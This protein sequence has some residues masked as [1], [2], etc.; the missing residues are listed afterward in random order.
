ML[1]STFSVFSNYP[2]P[3]L[4]CALLCFGAPALM[5]S[6]IYA[7]LNIPI[8]INRGNFFAATPGIYSLQLLVQAAVG[9]IAFLFGRG[10]I[11]WMA[12]QAH[13][14][15]GE[16]V[17]LRAALQASV[18][19][20]RALLMSTVLYGT[21]ITLALAGLA[22]LLREV[23]LEVSNFRWVRNDANSVLNVA[24]VRSLAIVPP[25]P[26]SPFAEL[27]AAT[28]YQLSRQGNVYFA[29]GNFP[30]DSR[31]TQTTSYRCGR[32]GVHWA[33]RHRNV[34]VYAQRSHHA[35]AST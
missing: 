9:A 23:R 22:V 30:F 33:I 5:G 27:H 32:I 34:I 26:G 28:R 18:G 8:H 11:V 7:A 21:L 13:T 15:T 4:V 6:A 17:S 12:Q 1:H 19:P 10:A 31:Q 3:V 16:P 20:W 14:N 29:G 2:I 25:D 35:V 24:L